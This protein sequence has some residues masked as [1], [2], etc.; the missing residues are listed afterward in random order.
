MRDLLLWTGAAL[1][2]LAITALLYLLLSPMPRRSKPLEQLADPDDDYDGL[3]SL[4][5]WRRQ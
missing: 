1:I 2:G 5:K 3:V 4:D